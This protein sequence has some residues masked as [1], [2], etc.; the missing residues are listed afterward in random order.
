ML[1]LPYPEQKQCIKKK[2]DWCSYVFMFR[3]VWT[4]SI[5]VIQ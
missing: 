5:W 2:M 1:L 4:R 3:K